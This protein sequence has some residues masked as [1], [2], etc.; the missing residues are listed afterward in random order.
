MVRF[1]AIPGNSRV[2]L[3]DLLFYGVLVRVNLFCWMIFMIPIA[4]LQSAPTPKSQS[5]K[6]KDYKYATQYKKTEQKRKEPTIVSAH[7]FKPKDKEDEVQ[8][9][10]GGSVQQFQSRYADAKE[11]SKVTNFGE[12]RW[13]RLSVLG[14]S[15]GDRSL[16]S[17]SYKNDYIDLGL[18]HRYKS[19]PGFF[20]AKDPEF[21]NTL[22][23]NQPIRESAFLNFLPGYF[24]P[25][26]F[27][28]QD[29][30]GDKPGF[31]LVFPEKTLAVTY[32]PETE[33]R[34]LYANFYRT[35]MKFYPG[36]TKV[37]F[38]LNGEAIGTK[39]DYFGIFH[40]KIEHPES[41]LYLEGLTYKD[42]N[43]FLLQSS[44]SFQSSQENAINSWIAIGIGPYH[45]IEAFDSVEIGQRERYQSIRWGIWETV[46]GSPVYRYRDYS[47]W[48]EMDGKRF[49]DFT[50]ADAI[51]WMYHGKSIDW[52]IGRE[53]RY[54]GDRTTEAGLNFRGNGWK[55]ET[56]VLF[57]AETN[58]FR[59]PV[60]RFSGYDTV[61][62]ALSDRAKILR[63]RFRTE[64]IEWNITSS[65]R[66]N[67]EGSFL[68]MNLQYNWIF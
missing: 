63:F 48:S 5:N 22:G 30:T 20:F 33:K 52:L 21:Y 64:F 38:T 12:M 13:K 68:F 16:G 54:N 62:I 61:Q 26:I 1:Y 17:I 45:R 49:E 39:T 35:P 50:R 67:R 56:S 59:S 66:I 18:G 19:I 2:R 58:R 28:S 46:L 40:T 32:S 25:G 4:P 36:K 53:I 47:Y 15:R 43:G 24:S 6:Q 42:D 44:D 23:E 7:S 31:S 9:S 11:S 27:F 37:L 34:S 10:V 29:I 41:K 14:E 51:L 60:E 8:F 3:I 57:Q 65:E 55:L